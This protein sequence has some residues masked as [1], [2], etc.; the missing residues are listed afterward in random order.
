MGEPALILLAEQQRR[1]DG[2]QLLVADENLGGSSLSLLQREQLTIV[3]NRFDLYQRATGEGFQCE[4]SDFALDAFAESQFAQILYRV[5]KEKSVAHHI[6]NQSRRLLQP[7]GILVLAGAKGDGIKTYADKAGRYLGDNRKTEKHGN[8]YVV[9]LQKYSTEQP[10]LD[11][12]DYPQLRPCIDIDGLQLISKPG[13]FGWNKV[14]QGSALLAE[15][16]PD[17]FGQF[18]TPPGSILDLGCGYGYL[19]VMAARHVQAHIVATDNNAAALLSCQAN[20]AVLNIDGEVIA[21]DCGDRIGDR[22]DAI[23]CNPPFHQGFDTDSDLTRRFV[24]S[25]LRHLAPEGKALFV[26][27]R[28]VPLEQSAASAGLVTV[29]VA[30]NRSFKLLMLEQH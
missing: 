20:F 10:P 4:F 29:G 2:P 6:I 18:R 1:A 19:S 22:F 25:S 28:F 12:R 24:E 23:I 7:D 13:Q 26:V 9:S 21:S 27:N 30:E 17:F 5:S 15:H 14:D 11:D 8:Y 3:T 16:L